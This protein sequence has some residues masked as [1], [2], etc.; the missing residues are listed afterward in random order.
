MVQKRYEKAVERFDAARRRGPH[1]TFYED[2]PE[3]CEGLERYDLALADVDRALTLWPGRR[4]LLALR[5]RLLTALQ[6]RPA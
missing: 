1:W 3:A 2:R 4:S 6:Q 5:T